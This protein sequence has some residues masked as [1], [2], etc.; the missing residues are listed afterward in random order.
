MGTLRAI[1]SGLICR[2]EVHAFITYDRL[3][4][5]SLSY[6]L[7]ISWQIKLISYLDAL[8]KICYSKGSGCLLPFVFLKGVQS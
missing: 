3:E 5:H 2:M 7:C 6:C 8:S 1:C 4:R